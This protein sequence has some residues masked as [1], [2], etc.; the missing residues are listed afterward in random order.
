ML[1]KLTNSE[2]GREQVVEVFVFL[3]L[4]EASDSQLRGPGMFVSGDSFQAPWK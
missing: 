4:Q 1:A 3:S 2:T